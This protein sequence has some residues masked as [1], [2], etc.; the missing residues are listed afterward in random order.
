METYIEHRSC[1]TLRGVVMGLIWW[2]ILA[3][4][5]SA[6]ATRTQELNEQSYERQ[7]GRVR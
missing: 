5:F 2:A 1:Y 3:T 7:M 6:V 4:L